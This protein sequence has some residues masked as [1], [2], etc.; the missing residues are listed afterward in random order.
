M[1]L[2]FLE[3]VQRSSL[4]PLLIFQMSLRNLERSV[5]WA[6]CSLRERENVSYD[7]TNQ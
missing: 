1:M 7:A 6:T 4:M 3:V 2:G 5:I